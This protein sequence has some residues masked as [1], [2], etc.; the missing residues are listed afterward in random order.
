L[1]QQS[2]TKQPACSHSAESR[3]IFLIRRKVL[4]SV[5]GEFTVARDGKFHLL[6]R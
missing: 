3:C 5:L 2:A 1:A 4:T 6:S